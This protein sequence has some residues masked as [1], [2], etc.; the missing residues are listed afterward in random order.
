[1][2]LEQEGSVYLQPDKITEA[3]PP[4]GR[5]ARDLAALLKIGTAISG[6]RKAEDLQ[7][8]VLEISSRS[9]LGTR[10][11]SARRTTSR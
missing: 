11:D 4:S 3:L 6:I 8:R 5:L 10:G 7:V 1:M 9:C 2:K